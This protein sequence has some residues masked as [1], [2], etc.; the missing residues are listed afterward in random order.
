MPAAAATSTRHLCPEPVISVFSST[1]ISSSFS[2]QSQKSQRQTLPKKIHAALFLPRWRSVRHLHGC[3]S[4]EQDMEEVGNRVRLPP[5][6]LLLS[7]LFD[8]FDYGGPDFFFGSLRRMFISIY[9]N[10]YMLCTIFF[11]CCIR[12]CAR[13]FARAVSCVAGAALL[14]FCEPPSVTV[15][16]VVQ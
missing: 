9:R 7:P 8:F 6:P 16:A 3:T 10:Y 15:A 2:S 14:L 4:I 13:I 1:I 5:C 12:S 11:P